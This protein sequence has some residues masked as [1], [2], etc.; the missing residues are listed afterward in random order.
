MQGRA[1][2]VRATACRHDLFTGGDERRAH[3]RRVF[4]TTAAAVALLEIADERLV[5]KGK[6]EP[7]LERQFDRSGEI[8]AQVTVDLVSAIAENFSGIKNIFWI[9]RIFDSTHDVQQ[10]IA[11]L[12]VHILGACDADA[13][14]R[15]K[16]A[17]KL[18]N[19]CRCFVRHSSKLF[20]ITSLM[21]IQHRS[22][23]QQS[24]RGMSVV[25]C[26]EP[27]R[28]HDR[29]QSRDICRQLRRTNR[30]VLDE[31]DRFCRADT[32]GQKRQTR[33]AHRPNEIHL[34]GLRQNFCAQ[35]EL[36]RLQYRQA[37]RDIVVELDD[38]NRIARF[39]IELH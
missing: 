5:L 37:F 10:F 3:H 21:Q 15:G 6:G 22:H 2:D 19:E 8:I 28:F 11:E 30:R 27:Q 12:F 36:S 17:A 1:D 34:G 32:T 18:P 7:R 29:F 33:L 31:R 9:E 4:A 24:A 13:V 38:Q 35:P 26:F 23:V 14:F 25:T 16:R 39:R 20:Q